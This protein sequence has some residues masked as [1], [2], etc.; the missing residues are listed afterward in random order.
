VTGSGD[1]EWDPF[2]T[3]HVALWIG[4]AQWAGKSTVARIRC[5][6]TESACAPTP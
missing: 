6:P 2:G 1:I 5:S 4:G 3:L